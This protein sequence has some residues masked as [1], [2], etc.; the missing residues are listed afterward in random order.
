MSEEK[1]PH[2]MFGYVTCVPDARWEKNE[3]VE[4]VGHALVG[5]VPLRI[6]ELRNAGEAEL[7]ALAQKASQTIAEKGD[8]FQ[9]Q[10]DQ[11]RKGWKPSGVLAELTTAYA[12]LAIFTDG[13]ITAFG[14]HACYFPHEGCPKERDQ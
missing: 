3:F 10:G 5:L 11:R 8:V 1:A 7:Q 12:V 9:Y 13:G 2:G 6:S 14:V 4:H